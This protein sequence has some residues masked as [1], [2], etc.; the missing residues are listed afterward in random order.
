MARWPDGP[1]RTGSC[2]SLRFLLSQGE[3]WCRSFRPILASIATIPPIHGGSDKV[4]VYFRSALMCLNGWCFSCSL[5]W[6]DSGSCRFGVHPSSKLDLRHAPL[7]RAQE[8][9]GCGGGRW[10]G[11]HGQPRKGRASLLFMS[12]A[13]TQLLGHTEFSQEMLCDLVV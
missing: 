9:R 13:R 6:R 4:P 8:K 3:Y 7:L 10:A 11:F 5:R 2:G 1:V 12:S